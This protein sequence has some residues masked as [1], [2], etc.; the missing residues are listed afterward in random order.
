M[1]RQPYKTWGLKHTS[2]P[3]T[4]ELLASDEGQKLIANAFSPPSIEEMLDDLE[5]KAKKFLRD[6]KL[7]EDW[8]THTGTQAKDFS[9]EQAWHC[10]EI[11]R[12]MSR[13]RHWLHENNASMAA[14][15]TIHMMNAV[16]DSIATAFESDIY[17]GKM[18]LKSASDGGKQKSDSHAVKRDS[19]QRRADEI[20]QNNPEHSVRSVAEIIAR[21]THESAETIRR[22]I[23]KNK[24]EI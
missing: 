22:N 23:E 20:W 14:A 4:P 2:T 6:N 21:E 5:A 7:D 19:W 17:R 13:V 18:S 24:R 3:L 8:R 9:D 12:R 16:T 1:T 15:E 10:I 11:L